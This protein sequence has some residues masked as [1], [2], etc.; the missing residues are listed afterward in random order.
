MNQ[1]ENSIIT[2]TLQTCAHGD[3]EP[4]KEHTPVAGMSGSWSMCVCLTQRS[5]GGR[6]PPLGGGDFIHILQCSHYYTCIYC[7][8]CVSTSPYLNL[9]EKV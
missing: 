5:L 7:Y 1:V 4:T 8:A 3:L 2:I 6:W 9:H